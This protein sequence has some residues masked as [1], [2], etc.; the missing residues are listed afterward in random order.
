M[1]EVIAG[2]AA[3]QVPLRGIADVI[4][5][6]YGADQWGDFKVGA[7]CTVPG[8]AGLCR[9]VLGSPGLGWQVVVLAKTSDESAGECRSCTSCA[10]PSSA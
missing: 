3:G 10:A 7:G 1:E 6:R 5:E 8:C 4:M 2:M 9:A